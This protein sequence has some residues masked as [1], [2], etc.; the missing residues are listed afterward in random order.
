V[1]IAAAFT[2]GHYTLSDTLALSVITPTQAPVIAALFA[3]IDP[4]KSYPIT[5]DQLTGFFSTIEPGA[6]RFAI[7]I[8]GTLAGAVSLRTNWFRGPYIQTF[9][10][11]PAHQGR[12]AGATVMA[13]IEREA[14]ATAERN[15]W[16]AV[17]DFNVDAQRFYVR[18]GFAQTAAIP[19]LVRDGRTELLLRKRLA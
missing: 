13:F 3:A 11:G 8:D 1:A 15:L 12:G 19:D 17:S 4:W 9:A 10:L 6:P 18:H 16:V 7:H 5:A 14:R 2:A